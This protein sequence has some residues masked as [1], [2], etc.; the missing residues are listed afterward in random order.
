MWIKLLSS[1]NQNIGQL[2]RPTFVNGTWHKPVIQGRQK[3]Q[4]KYYFEKA[5]VP[6][7]YDKERPE[8]HE[9]STYNRRPKGNAHKNQYETR[10]AVIRKNLSTM[11][12][13]IMKHRMDRL[14]NKVPTQD[15]TML[16]QVHKVLNQS[17]QGMQQQKASK[18]RAAKKEALT[19]IGVEARKSSPVKSARGSSRGGSLSKKLRET[20]GM[21]G[22]LMDMEK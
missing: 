22:D 1:S 11:D 14:V 9:T 20:S 3:A 19:S 18:I 17:G 10:L 5:G 2:M 4:L 13:K 15:E 6:W 16:M 7:I 8:V 21:T 12:E